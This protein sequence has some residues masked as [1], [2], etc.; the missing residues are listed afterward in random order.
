M[1]SPS[2]CF[3]P[4]TQNPQQVTLTP[5][6]RHST[7]L[8]RCRG[9][10]FL[11]WLGLGQLPNPLQQRLPQVS[12][13]ALE[14]P[15]GLLVWRGGEQGRRRPGSQRRELVFQGRHT[16]RQVAPEGRGLQVQPGGSTYRGTLSWMTG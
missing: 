10:A 6:D 9:L 8:S 7:H 4:R 3:L 1:D 5:M 12:L 13:Y 15:L 16:P 2:N 14:P 11:W